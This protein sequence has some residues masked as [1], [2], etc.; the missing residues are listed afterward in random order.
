MSPRGL[1]PGLS[2]SLSECGQPSQ[3]T[4]AYFCTDSGGPFIADNQLPIGLLPPQ[5]KTA[6]DRAGE[7]GAV[8][9]KML[10]D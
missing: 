10:H 8:T 9:L 3:G 1:H 2:Q 4:A 6:P 5:E 7:E